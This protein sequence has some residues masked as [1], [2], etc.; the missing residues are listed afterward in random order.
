[1]NLT[2]GFFRQ[3]DALAFETLGQRGVMLTHYRKKCHLHL[4]ELIDDAIKKGKANL[5]EKG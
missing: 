1:M 4:Q 2:P 5:N 3:S